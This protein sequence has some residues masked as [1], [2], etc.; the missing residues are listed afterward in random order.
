[1]KGNLNMPK[2]VVMAVFCISNNQAEGLK[3]GIGQRSEE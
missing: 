1:M 3:G 2:G